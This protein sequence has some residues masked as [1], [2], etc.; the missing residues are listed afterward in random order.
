MTA[1][2]DQLQ[3]QKVLP[4]IQIETLDCALPLAKILITHGFEIMEITLRSDIALEAIRRIKKEYPHS[5]LSA[6]TVLTT[7]Q[8]NA[9]D[10]AGTD[11]I[12]SPGFNP[13][14]FNHARQSNIFMIPGV[15]SPSDIEQAMQQGA[16]V[17]KFFPSE[18]SGG[19]TMVKSLTAPYRGIRF[20]PTGG[21][22]LSNLADYLEIPQVIA[23]GGTWLATADELNHHQWDKIEEKVK[24]TR[25]FLDNRINP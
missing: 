22:S 18:A 15:N 19:V 13:V 2:L 21:I 16:T 25:Q 9:A 11:F 4:V 14:T 6:G 12:I 8:V 10:K 3:Q 20:I 24:K 17:L 5:V 7:E 23:C 1:I